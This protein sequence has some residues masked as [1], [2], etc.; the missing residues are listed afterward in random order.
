MTRGRLVGD[1]NFGSTIV[2]LFEAP[3]EFRFDVEPG[4]KVKYGQGLS[5]HA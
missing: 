2:L 4:Q 5:A 1:F 3:A